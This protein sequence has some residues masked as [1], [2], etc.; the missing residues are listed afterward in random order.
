LL[1][2]LRYAFRTLSK[3]RGSAAVA[4]ITLALGIG[5]CTT[6]FSL[7]YGVFFRGLG[8]PEAGQ[9]RILE[10][11]RLTRDQSIGVNQHDLYDWRE[12]Q[13]A[14]QGIAGYTSGGTINLSDTQRGPERFHGG[15]VS[16][17]IFDLLRVTPVVGTAFRPGDDAPGAPLTVVLGYHVWTTRYASDPKVIGTHTKLNG[18]DA[19]I[20]GV[21]AGGFAFPEDAQLWV[22]RRDE[23]AKNPDRKNGPDF[24]AFARLKPGVSVDQAKAQMATIAA[25]L[26]REFPETNKNI[27]VRFRTFVE[28]DPGIRAIFGGMQGATIFVLLI[29]CANVANLLLARATMRTKEAALRTAIGASPFR[30]VLP[31][32]AET[33]WLAGAGALVGTGIAYLGISA[34]DRATQDVGKPYYMLF[35]LD[36]PVLGFVVA[37]TAL[38]AVV[39]GLA[40]ALQVLK[41]DL[42]RTLKDEDRGSSGVLGGR[43]SRVL[44]VAEIALSCALLVGAGLMVK[45]LVK[46]RNYQY[47]FATE[48]V[49][50]GRVGLFDTV[51]PDT[52]ARR[53]FWQNL[54]VRLQAMPG[55][56]AAALATGLPGGGGGGSQIAIEGQAYAKD[57]DYP[58]G[59]RLDGITPGFFETFD[60]RMLQ[61]RAFTPQDVSGSLPVAIINQSFA[62]RYFPGVN[63]IG[64]RIRQGTS[65]STQPW[66]TIVGVAP[67][68][69]VRGLSRN[70]TSI[71]AY[72]IPVAQRN[73]RFMSLAV[74]VTQGDGLALG[75]QVR[76]IVRSLDPDLPIYDVET[77]GGSIRRQAWF[78][79]VF[80]TIFIAFGAAALFMASVG[81]YGVLAFSVSRRIREM[82][83]RMAL[84]ATAGDVL[85][86]IMRQGITQISIGLSIGLALAL[87]LT[88]L[89]RIIMFDV[90]PSDPPVFL[91]IAIVIALVGLAASWVPARRATTVHPIE[92]LRYE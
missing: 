82:G 48:T 40:P 51:Y 25:D 72:Y 76:A 70:A 67:D 7:V 30:V 91:T 34:F 4:V 21:M 11:V 27:G 14:F 83:I 38:T 60:R 10:R 16:A 80:G 45:S 50:T 22:A 28:D 81:L 33:A 24:E 63:P 57:E 26:A 92:A 73:D 6:T 8:V 44:V 9:L 56:A 39:A 69:G 78:F 84:G 36:L 77:M 65:Q 90:N 58:D 42:N 68:L 3:D 52:T 12:R 5:L 85:R 55:V 43:V 59:G 32:F 37:V 86:M 54:L 29:A 53:Q 89:I 2:D 66:R 88:R 46:L 87:A 79:Q 71:R 62:D 49:F 64:R 23:R 47:P 17:N 41:T 31:F 15:F 75:S 20:L 1:Q 61:G 18:E 74:R 19:T 35:K 13:T